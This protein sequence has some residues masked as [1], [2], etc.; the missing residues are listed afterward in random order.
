MTTSLRAMRICGSELLAVCRHSD[1]S[2]D[3]KHCDSG[4][5]MFFICQVISREYIFLVLCEFM[6]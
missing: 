4:G 5:F 1:K 6:T 2:Y 3:H